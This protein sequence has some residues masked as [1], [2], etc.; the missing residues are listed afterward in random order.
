METHK[1]ILDDIKKVYDRMQTTAK[2]TSRLCY[3]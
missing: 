1:I 2:Y 3:I